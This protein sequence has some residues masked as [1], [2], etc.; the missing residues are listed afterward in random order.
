M[1]VEMVACRLAIF[2]SSASLSF[3]PFQGMNYDCFRESFAKQCM[4][5]LSVVGI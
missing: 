1:S 4:I 3:I 5:A 2:H